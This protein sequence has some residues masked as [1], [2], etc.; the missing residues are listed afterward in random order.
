M[1]HPEAGKHDSSTLSAF[2][3]ALRDSHSNKASIEKLEIMPGFSR[4]LDLADELILGVIEQIEES[5]DLC[6]FALTCSRL[7]SL[8]EPFIYRSILIRAG[9]Q[10]VDLVM[11]IKARPVRASAVQ[12]LGIRYV[13]DFEH[14]IETLN[15]VLMD[16]RNLR[17]LT[18]ESPC[19][20][21]GPWRNGD[22]NWE[23]RCRIDYYTLFEAASLRLPYSTPRAIPLLQSIVLH[24]HGDGDSAFTLGK[25]AIMFLHPTVRSITISCSDITDNL[26]TSDLFRG[27]EHS[28]PLTN[29]VFDECNISAFGLQALLS[30]P[31][32]L[33]RLTLGERLYHFHYPPCIPLGNNCEHFMAALYTQHESLEYIK[34]IGSR[35][36]LSDNPD[37]STNILHYFYNLRTLELGPH[38]VL[39]KYLVADEFPGNL[40]SLRLL[41]NYV[42]YHNPAQGLTIYTHLRSPRVDWSGIV[43]A[44]LSKY[45]HVKEVDIILGQAFTQMSQ[46]FDLDLLHSLW[47]TKEQRDDVYQ[48]A[49][50]LR[51]RG[52]RFKLFAEHFLGGRVFIPPYLYGEDVPQELLVYDSEDPN[53]FGS[54]RYTEDDTENIESS[55]VLDD[56]PENQESIDPADLGAKVLGFL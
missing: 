34:H 56:E 55:G 12:T 29:L 43:A 51:A 35:N 48:A 24:A 14:D 21:N 22:R 36:W 41:S 37:L 53:L 30:L 13:F 3:T 15:L 40:E 23:S 25:N 45:N 28:T 39:R 46:G 50:P 18:I 33:K 20:N 38:S 44:V 10:A 27:H 11:S 4:L 49:K 54:V 8:V 26:F 16:F 9:S 2:D 6:T 7:Q 32:A 19:L 42:H 47:Q 1:E 52:T 31:R 17:H 5:N